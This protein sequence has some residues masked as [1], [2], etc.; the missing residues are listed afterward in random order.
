MKKKYVDWAHTRLSFASCIF[1]IAL[2]H[3]KDCEE[4]KPKDEVKE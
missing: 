1:F 4:A 3:D 2:L